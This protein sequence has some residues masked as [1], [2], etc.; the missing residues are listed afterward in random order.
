MMILIL[1]FWCLQNNWIIQ[2][3]ILSMR[4][5]FNS[6]EIWFK[7]QLKEEKGNRMPSDAHNDNTERPID[8]AGNR[9][10]YRMK[11]IITGRP[12]E[13]KWFFKL[14][15]RFRTRT[16]EVPDVRYSQ[17]LFDSSA[18]FYLLEALMKYFFDLI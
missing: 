2:A 4:T 11:N 7:E 16:S 18:T 9:R 12:K 6:K 13:L 14:F 5:L 15:V 10:S 8:R 1:I 17:W 3:K